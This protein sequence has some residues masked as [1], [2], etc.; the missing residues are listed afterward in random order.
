M[1]KELKYIKREEN[2]VEKVEFSS[3]EEL[4]S[5]IKNKQQDYAFVAFDKSYFPVFLSVSGKNLYFWAGICGIII[6]V[7]ILGFLAAKDG[8]NVG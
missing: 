3:M 1:I 7:V 8:V 5:L 6:F 2:D 4:K